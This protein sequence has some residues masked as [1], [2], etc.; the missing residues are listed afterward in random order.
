MAKILCDKDIR[1][2]LPSITRGVDPESIKI[3]P[4][5]IELRLGEQ[6][7]FLST[8]EEKQ[9]PPDA[10]LKLLPSESV[11]VASKERIDFSRSAIEQR[12]PGKML[13][14]WITPSTT[15]MREGLH[16]PS[17]KVDAGF[18]CQLNWGL[19]NNSNKAVLL[20]AGERIFKLTLFLLDQDE[21]PE[22]PYGT[23]EEDVYQNTEGILTSFRKLPADI[24]KDKIV[25]SSFEDIDP[26]AHLKEVG[27]PFSS[28]GRE[29]ERLDGKIDKLSSR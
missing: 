13:M 3:N 22:A 14:A 28:I 7:R 11:I 15:I 27:F 6:V 5:G 26:K 24:A 19:R 9:I 21:V 20:N 18:Q 12:Y 17:T 10:Y 1:K 16:P 23:Q 4:N 2:L 25:G 8:K 29:F